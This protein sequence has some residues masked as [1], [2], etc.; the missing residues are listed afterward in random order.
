MFRE[1][2]GR[3]VHYVGRFVDEMKGFF[4]MCMRFC[5]HVKEPARK[6]RG[7]YYDFV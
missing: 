1:A 5:C 4:G 2:N 3:F 6:R 7:G